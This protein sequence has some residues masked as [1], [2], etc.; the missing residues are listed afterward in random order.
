M[1]FKLIKNCTIIIGFTLFFMSSV[2]AATFT[3][4]PEDHTYYVAI[5]SLKNL[6]IVNGYGDGTFGPGNAVNRAEALKMILNSAEISSPELNDGEEVVYTDVKADDWFAPFVVNGTSL[7]IINGNPDGSFAP[8]RQVNKVEF[9]KMLLMSFDVDLSKHQTFTSGI[10]ADT[11]KDDWFLPYLSYAKTLGLINPSLEN[12]LEPGKTLTRGQCA[13]IIYRMLVIERGG[14]AQK[15]LSI[16]ES[17][18]VEVVVYLNNNQIEYALKEADR[19]VFYTEQTLLVEPDDAVANAAN[20]I[21][22]GFR[23]IA[24]GY[25]AGVDLDAEKV[26]SY[27]AEAKAYADAAIGFSD[28][29]A[30]LRDK[31]YEIGDVLLMQL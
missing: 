15:L 19:A 13:E 6:G 27:V 7:G 21:A 30:S 3:D 24:K 22:E 8:A 17:S 9:L 20:K 2:G 18:L 5:E 14:D 4:V 25:K 31:I 23:S 16:A 1:V 29:V 11:S 28:T 10:S 12:L 26:Q